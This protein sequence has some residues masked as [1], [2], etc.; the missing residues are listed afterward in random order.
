MNAGI[1]I[2]TYIVVSVS[3]LFNSTITASISFDMNINVS[4]CASIPFELSVVTIFILILT[5]I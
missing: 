4:S 2:S 5:A 3:I 1:D